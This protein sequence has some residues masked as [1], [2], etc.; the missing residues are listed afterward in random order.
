LVPAAL[1]EAV[2]QAGGMVALV[3]P[4]P[5]L[6]CRELLR[7]LDAL[8]VF[9]VTGAPDHL[10]ALVDAAREIALDVLVLD[11]SRVTFASKIEDYMRELQRLFGAR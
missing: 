5:D 3:P 9:D 6:E 10:N 7:T 8:I 4:D 1:V 2:Q 11:R